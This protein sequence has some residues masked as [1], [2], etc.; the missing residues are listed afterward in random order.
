MKS[1]PT[2]IT[3]VFFIWSCFSSLASSQNADWPL[4]GGQ[5][6]GGHFSTATKITPENVSQ[7]KTA[8]THRSGD[9]RK[10][11]NFRDGLKPDTALQS[12]WQA[13]PVL[14]GDN[15]VI[16]TPFNRIIAINAATGEQQWSYTPD[17]N[18]D[19][20]AMPRC[21]GVTQWQHPNNSSNDSCHSVIIAPLMNAKVI[22][23]DAHT[24]QRC[25]FGAVAEINLREGLRPHAPG[26][27]TLNTPPAI[28]GNL[29]ITGAAVADNISVDVPSGVVRAYDL[30]TGQLT[31]AWDPV[32]PSVED[33][34]SQD[35]AE[36]QALVTSED[37]AAATAHIQGKAGLYQ[38]GTS[39]VWSFISVDEKL[40]RVYVPTGNTSP[41]YYGGHRKGSDF[42]SS[43]VVALEANTGNVIWHYQTVHHD[44]WDFDVPSQPTLFDVTTESGVVHG[45][46][47][48]TKQG[49]VFLLDRV[50]GEPLFPVVEQPMPQGAIAGDYTA[51]T[52][53]VPSKPRSLLD[54]PGDQE[55]VWGLTF[56]DRKA[57]ANVLEN[58][59]YEGPFTPTS[60]EGSLHMPSAFGGQNWGGPAL[61]PTR[62]I[63]VVNTQH[64][65]TVV[66]LL[67]REECGPETGPEP[68]AH[69]PFLQEP[70]EGTPYCDRR[71]LGFV[72]PLGAPCT[73]PPWGTLAGIDLVTGEVQWQVPLGTSRDMAPF[74]FWYIKGSPNIGGPVT[75]ASGLTF[76]A[77][78]TDRY[79]R[80]FATETGDELWK[81]RLPTTAHGLPITYQLSDGEQYVVVAAGGH[82][83][84]GT[85]PGDH[86]I[87]FKLK[88]KKEKM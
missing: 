40:N 47:Q 20:Y 8:W 13:T 29:L 53:P 37:G 84:L 10:G 66:Q 71:W 16:C 44:I 12:S 60:L 67:P 26:D 72:S 5:A 2:A 64:V 68:V 63:L 24:G 30:L 75:T 25:H 11:A 69:G 73:P 23:L 59:R 65:G 7:L 15:L 28:L 43:S 87:A 38:P 62:N 18:L 42:Y 14:A 33:R 86:L 21:R 48:T 6:G 22:G 36:A 88:L 58:L 61:D 17:I 46:A 55:T 82:A 54:L 32:P 4:P 70:S 9:F 81:G 80:A 27:Y 57:C 34:A 50:T 1:K 85:P 31:W 79:L 45:L 78:T 77:A 3:A 35:S 74:P 56:W 51:A 52:Q 76:I 39:N 19:D 49:Y 41:D 83:A